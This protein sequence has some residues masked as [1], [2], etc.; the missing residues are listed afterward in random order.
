M[1]Q[2]LEAAIAGDENRHLKEIAI[3]RGNLRRL[4]KAFCEAIE[5]EL[6]ALTK[7]RNNLREDRKRWTKER[8][9]FTRNPFK[10]LSKLL[11]TKRSGELKATKEQME[12]HLRQVHSDRRREDSME[13]MEKLIKPAEPTIPFG[14]EGPSWQEVNNFLKKARGAYS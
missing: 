3:L 1:D 13:E 8:V 7:I 11:G 14:A 5:V 6:P 4:K 10:Y 12:E 2:V 9:D